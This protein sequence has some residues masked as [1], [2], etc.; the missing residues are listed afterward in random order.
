VRVVLDTNVL[1]AAF[2]TWGLCEALF[3]ACLEGHQL[4]SSEHIL[5]EVRRHLARAFKM[6][7]SQAN[8]IAGFLREHSG[9][10]DPDDVPATACRDPDDLPVLGTA[11]AG[12]V[13]MLVTG[14]HDLLDLKTFAGFRILTPRECY[15]RLAGPTEP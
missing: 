14:D 8:R 3:A 7:A 11:V 15:E 12:K 5:D 1:L 2:G 10:V 6:P 13:D 4:V 9:L